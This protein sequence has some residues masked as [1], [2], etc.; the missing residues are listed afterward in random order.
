MKSHR[1]KRASARLPVTRALKRLS[2]TSGME[3]RMVRQLKDDEKVVTIWRQSPKQSDCEVT[4][5]KDC[6]GQRFHGMH[7][8][9]QRPDCACPCHLATG[10]SG[11]LTLPYALL[12]IAAYMLYWMI[13]HGVF[14]ALTALQAGR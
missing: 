14:Q 10:D 12:G 11:A 7:G 5:S 2:A 8:I 9:C 6:S 13:A 1:P 4:S 3:M